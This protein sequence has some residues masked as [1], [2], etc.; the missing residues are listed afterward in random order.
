MGTSIK[1]D[2]ETALILYTIAAAKS[3]SAGKFI[4]LMLDESYI[5]EVNHAKGLIEKKGKQANADQQS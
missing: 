4:R 1:V 3:I 5:E 2:N